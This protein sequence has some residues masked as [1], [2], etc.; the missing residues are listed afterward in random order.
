MQVDASYFTVP[1]RSTASST[2]V[3]PNYVK[4][5]AEADVEFRKAMRRI[6]IN[7]ALE[8]GD[9]ETARYLS[10]DK[11]IF[12][13]PPDME[14]VTTEQQTNQ[15]KENYENSHGITPA[16]ATDKLYDAL[17]AKHP[18]ASHN[19]ISQ[20]LRGMS[21]HEKLRMLTEL[22]KA[23][24]VPPVPEPVDAARE[25]AYGL[26][27]MGDNFATVIDE[28]EYEE[29]QRNKEIRRREA[30]FLAP[31]P[32]SHPI[33]NLNIGQSQPINAEAYNLDDEI[34]REIAESKSD[35]DLSDADEE[36]EVTP[37]KQYAV[38]RELTDDKIH[39]M[40]KRAAAKKARE[41]GYVNA[42][43]TPAIL[44][45]FL[46]QQLAAMSKLQR[47]TIERKTPERTIATRSRAQ[48]GHGID[49]SR[50]PF[51]KFVIDKPKL[52]RNI[53]SIKWAGSGQKVIGFNNR[54][55]SDNLKKVL[56]AKQIHSKIPLEDDE[57][58]LLHKLHLKA[59]VDVKPSKKAV[60]GTSANS[61]RTYDS[62][63]LIN[64][65]DLLV[66]EIASGNNNQ[67]LKNE[68]SDILDQMMRKKILTR[69]DVKD[70]TDEY[71]ISA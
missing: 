16:K 13:P 50:I 62:K 20:I 65:Y 45:E 21:K 2:V 26:M 59:D 5:K 9:A 17:M 67:A 49:S 36:I 47:S 18:N 19:E 55:I 37:T 56:T 40:N 60:I 53:L 31:R 68:L 14:L 48:L 28:D 64:R 43:A 52:K 7:N 63:Y 27:N 44:K 30:T 54:H 3:N 15:R 66:G 34:E 42:A 57:K 22:S 25:Q 39:R 38:L 35:D 58:E 32:R 70:I 12:P 51:G 71:I 61:G 10:G 29:R 24:Y 46:R 6:A 23:P 33:F 41:L 8:K 4:D 1:S 69:D 11:N